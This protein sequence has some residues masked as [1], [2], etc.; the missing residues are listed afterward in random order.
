ML[1]SKINVFSA[2]I[3]YEE[4]IEAIVV[5][6]ETGDV[7]MGK[8]YSFW[9]LRLMQSILYLLFLRSFPI[10]PFIL[11]ISWETLF[12]RSL[13]NY[14]DTTFGT[15]DPFSSTPHPIYIDSTPYSSSVNIIITLLKE[16]TFVR[17]RCPCASSYFSYCPDKREQNEHL[18]A[19]WFI[20]IALAYIHVRVYMQ[21]VFE[22]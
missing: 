10:Q 14:K 20:Y 13:H 16:E 9:F 2:W 19:R 8:S 4:L 17:F 3:I 21:M 18:Q 11:H 15:G 5:G 6:K 22:S 12:I 1:G 7:L